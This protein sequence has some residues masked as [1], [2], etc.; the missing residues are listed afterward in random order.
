MILRRT[1][2]AWNCAPAGVGQK[3]GSATAAATPPRSAGPAGAG[4]P[5][6]R[7]AWT[8]MSRTCPATALPGFAPIAAG[9]ALSNRGFPVS[10][11]MIFSNQTGLKD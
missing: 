2:S 4:S 10:F 11:P 1:G 3:T 5:S 6:A 9:T 8:K 7:S